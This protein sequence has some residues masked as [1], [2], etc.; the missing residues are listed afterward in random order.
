MIRARFVLAYSGFRLQAALEVPSQG[1]TALFGPS[2]CGK[3]T[4]LRCVAGL[5]RSASG[6]LQVNAETWQD[7]TQQIFLPTHRRLLG[8]VFQ[9]PSLFAH[10]DVRR[11]L[12]FGYARTPAAQRK[13]SWDRAVD[14]L[15][16]GSL[17]HR[18]PDGL[19]GGE[20]QRVAIA[21]AVLAAPRLLLMDEP[22]AAL[23]AQ[24]KREIL[25][26]LERLQQEL[27]IPVLY[28][29]HQADEVSRLANHL[30]LL[31]DGQ[32]VASG[33]LTQM[34]ARLDLPTAEDEDA[35]VVIES[36]VAGHDERY[37]LVRLEFPGGHIF[38]G[39]EAVA[40]GQPVRLRI[41][42]RDVSV[43]LSEHHDSSILNR[44]PA[45]IVELA[46]ASNP[47]NAM[48][49]LEAGGTTLLAR[50]THRSVEQLQLTTGS[51]VW[52]QIKAVAVL[53]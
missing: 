6:F 23:D 3:S 47:A 19:S 8:F 9:E 11:N 24:R 7:D 49:R 46:S 4:L 44:I 22:L 26:F 25:P 53:Q 39:R 12:L 52:A 27:S 21:R 14:L 43:A 36:R 17:L 5:E 29:S 48:I 33:P 16:V 30:V 50:I 51:K 40:I 20:R 34:L 35:G 41:Q 28:V 31:R 45:T 42:A 18:M 37:H 32:V 15:D 38:V 1:V 2:G 13:I 10:L